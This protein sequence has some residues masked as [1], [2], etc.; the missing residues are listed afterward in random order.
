MSKTTTSEKQIRKLVREELKRLDE[1]RYSEE[2]IGYRRGEKIDPR[3]LRVG[4]IVR[5]PKGARATLRKDDVEAMERRLRDAKQNMEK[6]GGARTGNVPGVIQ[7]DDGSAH[8]TLR[9]AEP[10]N[11]VVSLECRLPGALDWTDGQTI[12]GDSLEEVAEK[13]AAWAFIKSQAGYNSYRFG[14]EEQFS[15][16]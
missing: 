16:R 12:R 9:S 6:R 10:G 1:G 2:G 15:R 4:A 5:N 14:G 13:A 7:H 11:W 3:K 8:Y